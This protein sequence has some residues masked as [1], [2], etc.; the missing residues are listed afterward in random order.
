MSITIVG[1]TGDEGFGL[2]LRLAKAGEDVVIGSRLQEK[3]ETAAAN[4]NGILGEGASVRGMANPDAVSLSDV[5]FVTVPFAGQ[6]DTYRS[7]A[8]AFRPNAVVCDC[9]SPLATAVGGRPWQVITP[10]QGSAAEQAKALVPDP[11]RMVSAFQTVS[12]DSLQ[13]LDHSLTGDVLVCGAD[14][15]AKAAVGRL[16]ELIPVLRWVDAGPLAM[17]R[18]IEPLTAILVMVNR[19]Y[20]IHSGGVAITGREGWGSPPP[21]TKLTQT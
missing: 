1:G 21:K 6:A 13:D 2:A 18:V 19:N 8:G 11:V 9:T 15:E 17:A 10:W 4:A 20:G 5:V 14:A 12:G 3:G 7:I 16:V